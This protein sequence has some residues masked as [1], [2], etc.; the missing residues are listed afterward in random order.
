M[1]YIADPLH[2]DHGLPSSVSSVNLGVFATTVEGAK[3]HKESAR[4]ALTAQEPDGGR[5]SIL[6]T[7]REC[8]GGKGQA[9]SPVTKGSSGKGAR[10]KGVGG[11]GGAG[12]VNVAAWNGVGGDDHLPG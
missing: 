12:R 7:L 8:V 3:D 9:T 10:E 11:K 6:K 1:R 5:P 4:D 2:E